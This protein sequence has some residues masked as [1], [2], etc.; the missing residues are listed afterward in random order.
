MTLRDW[1]YN[2]NGKLIV[3]LNNG[4][5]FEVDVFVRDCIITGFDEL[6]DLLT[7]GEVEVTDYDKNELASNF[8][9]I[10]CDYNAIVCSYT[11]FE[12][13]YEASVSPGEF[14]NAKIYNDK[15]FVSLHGYAPFP[16]MFSIPITL[17]D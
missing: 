6:V 11:Q 3:Y 8:E 14:V 7:S 2:D 15:I 10:Q 12:T 17:I 16:D 4:S 5:G 13:Q 1:E 9:L